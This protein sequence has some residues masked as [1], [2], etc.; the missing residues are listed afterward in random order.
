MVP[1][2]KYFPKK[3]CP[4]NFSLSLIKDWIAS[5]MWISPPLPGLSLDNLLKIV[6]G[7]IYLPITA[8]LDGADL[9]SG[10]STT[11]LI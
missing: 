2:S 4:M 8:L 1:Q 10:F 5:V 9:I 11:S 6:L 3:L 7:S